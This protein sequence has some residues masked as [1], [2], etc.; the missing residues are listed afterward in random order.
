MEESDD[1]DDSDSDVLQQYE[2]ELKN[3]KNRNQKS[4]KMVTTI[5]MP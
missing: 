1:D 2:V 5:L 4:L 3:I